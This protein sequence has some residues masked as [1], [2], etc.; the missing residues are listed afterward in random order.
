MRS[1]LD[2]YWLEAVKVGKNVTVYSRRKKSSMI[3]I[4]GPK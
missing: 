1:K 2:G 4:S 3:T